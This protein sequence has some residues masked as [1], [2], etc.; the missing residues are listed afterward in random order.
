MKFLKFKQFLINLQQVNQ[1]E[2]KGNKILFY[3]IDKTKPFYV[4]FKTAEEA[5][6]EFDKIERNFTAIKE[7]Q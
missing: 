5:A 2:L 7:H 4:N 3:F 1:I 6:F